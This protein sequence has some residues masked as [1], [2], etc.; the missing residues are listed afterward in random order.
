MRTTW[1]P[2][3]NKTNLTFLLSII[4][5]ILM[6]VSCA[7]SPPIDGWRYPN[8]SDMKDGW[9][10]ENQQHPQVPYHF[11]ADLNGDGL[12]DDAW[13]LLP[14]LKNSETDVTYGIFVFF[15]QEDGPP[16]IYEEYR[17]RW[18]SPQEAFISELK[19]IEF[20][21]GNRKME[22]SGI[23]ISSEVDSIGIYWDKETSSF[24][25]VIGPSH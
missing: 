11:S 20:E 6:L 19:P 2:F 21:T 7:E 12:S 14:T 1:K 22:Y 23:E 13:I 5:L 24:V 15:K 25:S 9:N 8:E 3:S 10:N 16:I 17:Q 18:G 4:F